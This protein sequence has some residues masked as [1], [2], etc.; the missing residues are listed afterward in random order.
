MS[1]AMSTS[2]AMQPEGPLAQLT[3]S[4]S[5]PELAADLPEL[6][7]APIMA[8]GSP[9]P[10]RTRLGSPFYAR[11]YGPSSASTL[12][13][14][15]QMRRQSH[16]VGARKLLKSPVR[17]SRSGTQKRR[18]VKGLEEQPRKRPSLAAA[19]WAPLDRKSVV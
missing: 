13:A 4:V 16:T 10:D 8:D 17:L 11:S 12:G 14:G 1:L 5:K 19:L 18:S 9:T 7:P 6:E 2:D 15:I 3:R